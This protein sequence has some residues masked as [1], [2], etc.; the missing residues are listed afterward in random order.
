M[1]IIHGF[2]PTIK[3]FLKFGVKYFPDVKSFTRVGNI[4][5]GIAERRNRTSSR[6]YKIGSIGMLVIS[7]LF[8]KVKNIVLHIERRQGYD[9]RE[10]QV[11]GEVLQEF[12]AR[13]KQRNKNSINIKYDDIHFRIFLF[14]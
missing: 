3:P 7:F 4:S 14:Q 5:L 9:I 1:R 8:M 13:L 6:L 2:T 11:S 10:E 12:Y